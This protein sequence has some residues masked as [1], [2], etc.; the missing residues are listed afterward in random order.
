MSPE[1]LEFVERVRDVLVRTALQAHEDAAVR[2]L[3]AE[4]AWR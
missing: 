1:A 4:E 3:S 2:G